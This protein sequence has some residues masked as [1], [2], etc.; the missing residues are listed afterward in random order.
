MIGAG[1]SIAMEGAHSFDWVDY[2]DSGIIHAVDE[3]VAG[4]SFGLPFVDVVS[5]PFR[6]L[7]GTGISPKDWLDLAREIQ[8]VAASGEV[9]GIVVTHGTATLEET[10]FFLHCTVRCGMPVV[11][12]GSQRPPNTVSSDAVSSVRNALAAAAQAP[13]G[14][15]VAMNGYLYSPADVSKTAN[16]ALD[17]FDAPEF[18]PL[19]R[20][21]ASGMLSMRRGALPPA[22]VFDGSAWSAQDFA[23]VDVAYSYAG[24]DGVAIDAYAAAGCAGLI[25]VGF[26]PGRCTP[27]ERAALLRAV[28]QGVTVVQA[29][30]AL[31]GAVPLQ[32]YNT[33]DGILSGGGLSPGKL[34]ILLMLALAGKLPR[35]EIQALLLS[36]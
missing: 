18:G 2:G 7:P 9:D 15:Y 35:Q 20:I 12:C 23:R 1:G 27:A 25:S 30:R 8:A 22:R 13:V 32:A 36:A 26:P 29:S 5:H 28:R 11:V 6:A 21:E 3:V 24:A 4:M 31:R 17:A 34:R 33:A 14:V 19:G 16:H 10:A